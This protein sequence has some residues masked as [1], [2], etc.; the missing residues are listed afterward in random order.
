MEMEEKMRDQRE[1]TAHVPK[2]IGVPVLGVSKKV[3]GLY[4]QRLNLK[5]DVQFIQSGLQICP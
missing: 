4:H 1:R 2:F 3:Q 5:S